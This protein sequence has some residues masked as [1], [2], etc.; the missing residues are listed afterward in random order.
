MVS[1]IS[2]VNSIL[3]KNSQSVQLLSDSAANGKEIVGKSVAMTKKIADDSAGLIE[4]SAVIQNIARQTNLLSMN[5]AIEAAHAGEAGKGFAVV[6]EEIRKLAEDSNKQGKNISNVMKRMHELIDEMVKDASQTQSQF[7]TIFSNTQTV[8]VQENEI[9]AAMDEQTEGG[10]QILD[11]IRDIN[12][13]T[14]DVKNSAEIMQKGEKEM[15]AEMEKLDSV[16]QQI[17]AAMNEISVG[18]NEINNSMQEVNNITKEN[19]DSIERV[20]GEIGLFKVEENA[21]QESAAQEDD[22][23]ELAE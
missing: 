23:E 20:S 19:A 22:S 18:V 7:D 16:T 11:A 12:N 1:N 21:A 15:L 8:S 6:A 10:K 5:A 3:A 4:A 17:N 2:S 9:K 14:A 13:I